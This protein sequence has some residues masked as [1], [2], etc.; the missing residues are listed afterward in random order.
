MLTRV[1]GT[2]KTAGGSGSSFVL[3]PFAVTPT[4][5]NAIVVPIA[6]WQNATIATVTDNFGNI[7]REAGATGGNGRA[8]IWYCSKIAGSGPTLTITVTLSGTT[9]WVASAIEVGVGADAL[10]VA[11]HTGASGVSATPATGATGTLSG[12]AFLVAA[13]NVKTNQASLTVDAVAPPWTEEWEQLL[14]T[15]SAAGEADSRAITGASSPVSVT[16]TLST[17]GPWDAHL[18]AF[19]AI[20]PPIAPVNT[21]NII[22]ASGGTVT[23]PA[24][25]LTTGNVI[26]VE[27]RCSSSGTGLSVTDTMGN[28]YLLLGR[29]Q[30][31]IETLELWYARNVIGHAANV[32]TWTLDRTVSFVWMR[33]VQF[34]GLGTAPGLVVTGNGPGQPATLPSLD[35]GSTANPLVIAAWNLLTTSTNWAPAAGWEEVGDDGVLAMHTIAPVPSATVTP[36]ATNDTNAQWLGV[37]ALFTSSPPPVAGATVVTQDAIELLSQ[38]GAPASRVSQEIVEALTQPTPVARVSQEVV[39]LLSQPTAPA[40]VTQ[41]AIEL[42]SQPLP[43][44]RLTH[45]VAETLTVPPPPA[46]RMTQIVAEVLSPSGVAPVETVRLSQAPV[47]ALVSVL[48]PPALQLAQAPVEALRGSVIVSLQLS[49][50][51][52]EVLLTEGTTADTNVVQLSQAPIEALVIEFTNARISQ[53]PVEVI[54]KGSATKGRVSQLP[55][56]V[57][58][59]PTLV[60]LVQAPLEV[61]HLAPPTVP[62][63]DVNVTHAV[64]ETSAQRPSAIAVTHAPLEIA[65][66]PPSDRVDVTQLPLEIAATQSNAIDLS[67][68]QIVIEVLRLRRAVSKD[69][70]GFYV[71]VHVPVRTLG[72]TATIRERPVPP[73]VAPASPPPPVPLR[74]GAYVWVHVPIR[75]ATGRTASFMNERA[76]LAARPRTAGGKRFYLL[77]DGGTYVPPTLAGVWNVAPTV[78]RLFDP[79]KFGGVATTNAQAE[80]SATAG[81]RL[82]V[83]RAISRRLAPQTISGTVQICLG[84]RESSTSADMQPRLHLAVVRGDGTVLGTLLDGY[85][86]PTELPNS[87]A[88]ISFATPRTL[89]SVVV[90]GGEHYLVAEIGCAAQNTVTTSFSLRINYGAVL[91]G[92]GTELADLTPGSDDV[93]NLAGFV[94]FSNV[95][96]LDADIPANVSPS[97]ALPMPPIPF[98]HLY[99][100]RGSD[101]Q[102]RIVWFTYVAVTGDLM[103]G[104]W[105]YGDPI[106]ALV[107]V[108]EEVTDT[109]F[110]NTA[111]V[112]TPIQIHVTVGKTYYVRVQVF[113][114]AGTRGPFTLDVLRP[115]QLFAPIGSIL[116]NDD[117]HDRP[118]TILS[119][120]TGEVL[121]FSSTVM[122]HGESGDLLLTG[123]LLLGDNGG[124][125]QAYDTSVDPF[126]LVAT[127]PIDA[128]ANAGAIR[129]QRVLQRFYVVS[130]DNPAVVSVYDAALALV[131]TYTLTGYEATSIAASN[132]GTVLYHTL[133]FSAGNP[134]HRW[135]TGSGA[136]GDLVAGD[137]AAYHRGIDIIVVADDSILVSCVVRSTGEFF[138]NRYSPA[139]TLLQ[140]YPIAATSRRQGMDPRLAQSVGTDTFAVWIHLLEPWGVSRFMEIRLSDGAIVRSVDAVEFEDGSS[141]ALASDAAGTTPTRFG[142]SFSC[143][144]VILPVPIGEPVVV[145]PPPVIAVTGGPYV[146][147]HVPVRT[148]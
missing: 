129:A 148:Q 122:A 83:F 123:L 106:T 133:A 40:R 134:I 139:G 63:E 13:L 81:T 109:V 59:T 68:T 100:A 116:I 34:R 15:A 79:A 94:E 72:P 98:T 70:L 2:A 102:S 146:W 105:A 131:A 30:S 142:P 75:E 89:T 58:I 31:G 11:Q 25:P 110:V 55:V 101:W 56:E 119:F 47:E 57:L 24:T 1:Q 137:A 23:L 9:W 48:S 88:G 145:E 73:V 38:P 41:D 78:T 103:L 84:L 71:W 82:C 114:D 52:V 111:D 125:V 43:A 80:T 85:V 126:T 61:L 49:Q 92:Q 147:V 66:H 138:V 50:A 5:G 35:T 32:V 118:A 3:P 65:E 108:Y 74:S 62:S 93:F 7:Y 87:A 60:R 112:N 19:A 28:E 26:V 53:L 67:A 14:T 21:R 64:L 96:A 77:N 16:W 99:D 8:A 132:D 143:P 6:L 90:P 4:V 18:V 97:T 120:E 86:E 20:A 44:V 51:P 104:L 39:E 135:N 140:T 10:A 130:Q 17:S 27:A 113:D 128:D 45:V 121:R 141:Q 107:R 54:V 46:V 69:P 144:F 124:T 127:L 136:M 115:P 91:D 29:R 76:R 95:I 42:L 117:S 12:D 22:N 36:S 33:S 37:A